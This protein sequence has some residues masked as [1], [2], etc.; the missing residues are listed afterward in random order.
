MPTCKGKH[1][2][3]SRQRKSF[4]ALKMEA[5][6]FYRELHGVTFHKAVIFMFYPL[7]T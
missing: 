7:R 5:A 2:I 1:L 6:K 4:S 3:S